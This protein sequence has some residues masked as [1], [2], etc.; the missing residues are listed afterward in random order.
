MTPNM[1]TCVS[2][3]ISFNSPTVTAVE[4][5]KHVYYVNQ[6]YAFNEFPV[7][8]QIKGMN[9]V[10]NKDRWGRVYTQA[11]ERH[12]NTTYGLDNAIKKQ[13]VAIWRNSKYKS[14]AKS[15]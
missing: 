14:T 6:F 13:E 4:A 9:I 7:E 12:I 8:N 11:V 10:I 2:V 3:E 1:L 15:C 5:A